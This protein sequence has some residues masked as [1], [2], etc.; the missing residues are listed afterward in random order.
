LELVDLVIFRCLTQVGRTCKDS[1]VFWSCYEVASKFFCGVLPCNQEHICE[2]APE[3]LA[4]FL[5][6]HSEIWKQHESCLGQEQIIKE[7]PEALAKFEMRSNSVYPISVKPQ[8]QDHIREIA[9]EDIA[10]VVARPTVIWRH[11]KSC[12][13]RE[14]VNE[15]TLEA[16]EKFTR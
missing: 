6:C 2:I 1:S 14:H 10:K 11:D 9:P 16:F 13:S 8:S 7:S 12:L 3:A 15:T 5:T 4:M